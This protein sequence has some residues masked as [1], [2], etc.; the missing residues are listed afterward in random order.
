MPS[1]SVWVLKARVLGARLALTTGTRSAVIWPMSREASDPLK[2]MV[3]V[4]TL[5]DVSHLTVIGPP[6]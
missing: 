3:K 5:L 6:V 4:L 2:L 1:L